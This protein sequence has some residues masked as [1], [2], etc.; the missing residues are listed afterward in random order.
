M[1]TFIF[2]IGFGIIGIGYVSMGRRR[3]NAAMLYSGAG[4]MLFPYV[5]DGLIKT[6]F[7]GILLVI[8]PFVTRFFG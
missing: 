7:I 6:I 8:V 5:V 4:L 2:S 3:D 1:E